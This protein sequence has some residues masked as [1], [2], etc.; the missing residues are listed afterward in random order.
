[1]RKVGPKPGRLSILSMP[2][3]PSSVKEISERTT[4]ALTFSSSSHIF[5][6]NAVTTPLAVN[7][8]EASIANILRMT[9]TK[10][11]HLPCSPALSMSN[12]CFMNVCRTI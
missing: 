11:A 7:L 5:A 4:E 3:V 1:M 9:T 2:D 12:Y 10:F 8:D 6:P